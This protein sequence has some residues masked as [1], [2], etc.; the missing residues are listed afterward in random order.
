MKMDTARSVLYELKIH[1][2]AGYF[3]FGTTDTC[4]YVELRLNRT[5]L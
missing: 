3:Y 5:L 4:S 1:T 2:L